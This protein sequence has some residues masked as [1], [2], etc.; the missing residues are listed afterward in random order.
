MVGSRHQTASR[1]LTSRLCSMLVSFLAPMFTLWVTTRQ[2]HRCHTDVITAATPRA[3]AL[4]CRLGRR[5]EGP[6]SKLSVGNYGHSEHA[7]YNSWDLLVP[8][9]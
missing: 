5:G 3:T 6:S 7:R 1:L 2:N 4:P 9:S 8:T